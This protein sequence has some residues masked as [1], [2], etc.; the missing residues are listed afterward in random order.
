MWDFVSANIEG[1]ND[2][3]NNNRNKNNNQL[4]NNNNSMLNIKSFHVNEYVFI[5][6]MPRRFYKDKEENV[7]YHINFKLQPHRFVGPYRI[8]AKLSPVIYTL[9]I[10]GEDVSMHI[11]H[12]KS[13]GKT[14]LKQRKAEINQ[15]NYQLKKDKITVGRGNQNQMKDFQNEVKNNLEV[16]HEDIQYYANDNIILNND[17]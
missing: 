5:R 3:I 17:P 6:H 10:H 16:I 14:S 2:E 15:K 4:S 1:K 11:I 12:M 9:D 13:A 8:K 7:K